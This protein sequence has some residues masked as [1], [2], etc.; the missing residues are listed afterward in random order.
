MIFKLQPK[1]LYSYPK[2]LSDSKTNDSYI[3][4]SILAFGADSTVLGNARKKEDLKY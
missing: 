2:E 3:A 4:E 1:I